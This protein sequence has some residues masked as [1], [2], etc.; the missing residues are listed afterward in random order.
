MLVVLELRRAQNQPNAN[1]IDVLVEPKFLIPEGQ[2]WPGHTT[3]LLGEVRHTPDSGA[4]L[5]MMARAYE[6]SPLWPMRGRSRPS[7]PGFGSW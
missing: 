6:P 3:G 5:R 7:R 1:R 4:G 2:A